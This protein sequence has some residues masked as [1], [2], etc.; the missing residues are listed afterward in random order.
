MQNCIFLGQWEMNVP[1]QTSWEVRLNALCIFCL[2]KENNKIYIDIFRENYL[3]C[4]SVLCVNNGFLK[5]NG[6]FV[7]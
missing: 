1:C 5:I 7:W 6:G 3:A 2:K 4:A